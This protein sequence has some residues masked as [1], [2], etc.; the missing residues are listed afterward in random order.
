MKR[1]T[2]VDQSSI[3]QAL[4]RPTFDSTKI[5]KIVLPILERVKR[6]GDKALRKFAL[7]YDHVELEDLWVDKDTLVNAG[8]QIDPALK[9]AILQAKENIHKFH[10]AQVQQPLE[11]EVT[12]GVHCSRKSVPIQ[13]VGLYVPGG[14][15]PL[16]STVLMLGIPAQI[17]GC[18]EI[19]IATPTNKYGE[20]NP[21]VLYTAHLL[22]IEKILK[23]GG[24]QAIAALA[25]GTE[26][27]PSVDKIFGPGNQYV[28]AAKQIV[29]R[30][31]VAIDMP[32]GPSEVMV[33]ADETTNP[34]FAAMD[35]L[36]QAEHGVDSPGCIGSEKK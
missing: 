15:A 6:G 21:V 35:L 27:V 11:M 10:L 23:V 5:E 12:K 9:E 16:F 25:Y 33:I 32:A 4:Q 36:S 18:G 34:D 22:G 31:T 17:A 24:A 8:K 14:T 20:V 29:S 7:E 19:I 3:E 28:T 2:Y 30:D 26:T 1:I 13:K